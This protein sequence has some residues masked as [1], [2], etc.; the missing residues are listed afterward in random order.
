VGEIDLRGA[1][2]IDRAALDALARYTGRTEEPYLVAAIFRDHNFRQ[3]IVNAVDSRWRVVH[4]TTVFIH[5]KPMVTFACGG[6]DSTCELRDALVVYREELRTGQRRAQAMLYQAKKWA[7]GGRGWVQGD[8]D[9][10]ALYRHWP[11]FEINGGQAGTIS[12]PPGDYGRVLGITESSSPGDVPRV[13]PRR[14]TE[15]WCRIEEEKPWVQVLGTLG[16]SVREIVRFAF[17]EPVTGYWA[18]AVS[19]MLSL[20]VGGASPG[21]SYGRTTA[22]GGTAGRGPLARLAA[23]AAVVAAEEE[24]HTL[25]DDLDEPPDDRAAEEFEA[26]PLSVLIIDAGPTG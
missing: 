4:V 26:A 15:P 21:R 5:K 3:A 9:Q 6:T 13:S 16:R 1:E 19:D 14:P 10:H 12:L 24:F 8:E 2:V 22:R 7:G 25:V 20:R 23:L 17:G 18:L 11:P